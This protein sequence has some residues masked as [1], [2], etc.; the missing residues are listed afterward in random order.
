M[1]STPPVPTLAAPHRRYRRQAAAVALLVVVASCGGGETGRPSSS[2]TRASS[3]TKAAT[4]STA[5]TAAPSPTTRPP[6]DAGSWSLIPDGPQSLGR[7]FAWTGTALL[8]AKSGCC[9]EVASVD[10]AAYDAATNTWRS[11][12]PTPP[13]P[14]DDAV[15]AW[16]GSE[17]IVAVATRAGIEMPRT[18]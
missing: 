16:T 14:R 17:M 7:P 4:T 11:L 10:L 18:V 3:T 2:T 15:G 5:T 9:A 12:P 6:A 8:A 13:T 1:I